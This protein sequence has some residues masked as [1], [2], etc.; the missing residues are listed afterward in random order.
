[1]ITIILSCILFC[2][3]NKKY[4]EPFLEFIHIPKNAG[5]TIENIANK[6]DI[7][8]GRMKPSHR[9]YAPDDSGCSYWH[10]PPKKFR[11][12][13]YYQ[14]D[15][16]FCV[17]RNPYDRIVS[18]YKY[19]HKNNKSMDNPKIM[20]EW[21]S[22]HLS[23]DFTSKGNLNC[24]FIPQYEFVYD[25][26]GDKTCDHVLNFNNLQK[27]FNDLMSQNNYDLRLNK[28]K[29]NS[30]DS[31]NLTSND[32]TLANKLKIFSIYKKDFELLNDY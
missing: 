12:D 8:W 25:D 16:T 5:T 19:R 6:K 18:E 26:Y 9:D 24:H 27:E 11:K 4:K 13:N 32:L 14:K 30:T 1:M 7:K 3:F 20:N 22:K 17:I 10:I 29:H 28:E 21:I 23:S 15:K 2:L 31:F